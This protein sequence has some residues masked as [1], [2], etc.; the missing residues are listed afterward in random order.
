MIRRPP[1]STLFPYTTLFRSQL[2]EYI[3]HMAVI[4][5]G[6]EFVFIDIGEPDG[7]GILGSQAGI[8]FLVSIFIQLELERIEVLVSGTVYPP[9]ISEGP[10]FHR[11][12]V[13]RNGSA[14]KEVRVVAVEAG[15]VYHVI[16]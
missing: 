15:I 5:G 16:A 1:R 10:L 3:L 13:I 8:S 2:G 4:E 11:V 12:L 7:I 14:G 9:A 6:S